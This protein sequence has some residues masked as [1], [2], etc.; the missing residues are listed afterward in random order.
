MLYTTGYCNISNNFPSMIPLHGLTTLT[1]I[2]FL[3]NDANGIV[4][5]S[6]TTATRP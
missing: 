5:T 6:S 3:G 1:V 2:L 4:S